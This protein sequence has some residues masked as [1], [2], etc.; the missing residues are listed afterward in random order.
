M[1]ILPS[2]AMAALFTV[3]S[4]SVAHADRQTLVLQ[5]RGVASPY[6]CEIPPT[7]KGTTMATCF[8]V[9]LVNLKT[10]KIVGTGTDAIAD[11]EPVGDA[12]TLTNTTFFRLSG[13][14]IVSRTLVNILPLLVQTDPSVTVSTL[15]FPVPGEKNIIATTG[16][17][18]NLTG[19]S[20]LTGAANNQLPNGQLGFSCNF[21]L[22][23]E[24]K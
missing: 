22:K 7:A 16:K 9:D 14:T 10:G 24:T 20:T 1:K 21:V 5:L 23:L 18:K 17:Y 13:G 11:V 19:T 6:T 4:L 12:M 3:G 15:G 2:M 8:D